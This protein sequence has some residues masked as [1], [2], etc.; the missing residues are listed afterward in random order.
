MLDD[1]FDD[2][3][4]ISSSIVTRLYAI[5]IDYLDVDMDKIDTEEKI[6]IVSDDD[7]SIWKTFEFQEIFFTFFHN[8]KVEISSG[9]KS[10]I[11]VKKTWNNLLNLLR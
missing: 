10:F 11:K 5:E 6:H 2:I 8:G 1:I 4:I 3:T 9:S 7:K